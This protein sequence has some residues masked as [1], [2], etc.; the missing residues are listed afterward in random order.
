VIHSATLNIFTR[1]L[2]GIAQKAFQ[3]IQEAFVDVK[4]GVLNFLD[5]V[6]LIDTTVLFLP[7]TWAI[8][9]IN[10]SRAVGAVCIHGGDI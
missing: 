8:M 4:Q 3:R 5:K 10:C 2:S 6:F 9:K 1:G 7:A